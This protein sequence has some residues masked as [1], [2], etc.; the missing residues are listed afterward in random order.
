M[1]DEKKFELL[2]TGK[3]HISFSEVRDWKD[4]SFRHKLKYIKKIDLGKPGPLLDFGTAV[5]AS[6]ENFLKT[7]KMDASIATN[8]I[9]NV[10]KKNVLIEGF[11]PAGMPNFI[12]EATSI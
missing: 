9:E 11:E 6:C 10:W 2:P 8:M 5:H 12:A 7:R 3:S 1:A 4:C